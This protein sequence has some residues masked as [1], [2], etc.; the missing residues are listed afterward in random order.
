MFRLLGLTLALCTSAS[1]FAQST[2]TL[3]AKNPALLA[4]QLEEM[5]LKTRDL[6][7]ENAYPTLVLEKDEAPLTL[8][9]GGC[10]ALFHLNCSYVVAVGLFDDVKDP[11]ADWVAKQNA[12]FDMTKV[13][14]TDDNILAF[15]NGA[16]IEGWPRQ[17]FIA[18]IVSINLASGEL[19]KEAV[20]AG[21]VK[22]QSASVPAPHPKASKD[23]SR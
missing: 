21:L 5:G 9:F 16:I 4:R 8:T 13:W 14:R 15:S 2:T 10:E 1:A 22:D 11:P 18:W 23:R 12:D 19:A 3:S 7:L 20:D 6:D 17:T